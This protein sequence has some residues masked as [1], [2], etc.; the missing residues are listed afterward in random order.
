MASQRARSGNAVKD[1]SSRIRQNLD[2]F[3]L[4]PNSGEL[5]AFSQLA[6]F[7]IVLVT[8]LCP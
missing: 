8:G 3:E 1:T 5:Y 6:K 2:C 7:P 4:G